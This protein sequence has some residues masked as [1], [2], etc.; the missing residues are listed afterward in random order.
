MEVPVFG[1]V[2]VGKIQEMSVMINLGDEY[3]QLLRT[4]LPPGPVWDEEDTFIK[5]LAL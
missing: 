1:D 2:H 4:L 3:T 5:G